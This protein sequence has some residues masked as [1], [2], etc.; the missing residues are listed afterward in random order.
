MQISLHR[1]S[2]NHCI[3][4]VGLATSIKTVNSAT[5]KVNGSLLH[6]VGET[7]LS[8]PRDFS[9]IYLKK[10]KFFDYCFY[11]NIIFVVKRYDLELTSLK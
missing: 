11:F 2:R 7:T 3:I 1:H 8:L 5:R 9:H 6:S 10:G 4:I